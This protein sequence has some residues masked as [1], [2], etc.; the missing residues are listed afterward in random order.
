MTRLR[1]ASILHPYE[2]GKSDADAGIDIGRYEAAGRLRETADDRG[3]ARPRRETEIRA[4]VH[5]QG[6]TRSTCA[7][8]ADCVKRAVVKAVAFDCYGTL[9]HVARPHG[10]Y[11]QIAHLVG[12]RMDPSPM[13]T[14][15]PLM[16][17]VREA[18]PHATADELD[19]LEA[20]L[21]DEINSMEI[22]PG[23]RAAV[24]AFVEA[25]FDLAI[26]SNLAQDYGDPIINLFDID[27]LAFS[28]QLGTRKPS[29]RFYGRVC[30]MLGATPA[31]VLM[32]GDTFASDYMGATSAGLYAVHLGK[33]PSPGVPAIADIGDL[34]EWFEDHL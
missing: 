30:H 18:A 3:A 9:V 21:D 26:A 5:D 13:T 6:R 2:R 29:P 23:A 15:R 7:G 34:A 17:M 24:A 32:V 28:Y 1:R 20:D 25:G 4:A 19:R 12:R 27:R 22:M 16:D 11:R 31:Q 10:V 33:A 8:R 14:E